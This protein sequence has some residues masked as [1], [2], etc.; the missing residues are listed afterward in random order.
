MEKLAAAGRPRGIFGS[1]DIK[2]FST[3]TRKHK[4]CIGHDKNCRNEVGV[5]HAFPR[6]LF[7]ESFPVHLS[8]YVF[9]TVDMSVNIYKP[10]GSMNF[11]M[12]RVKLQKRKSQGGKYFS[13]VVTL[14]MAI[15]ESLPEYENID[16]LEIKLIDGE[17][18]LRPVKRVN[19]I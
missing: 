18:V 9:T 5:E 17:I 10:Y 1:E 12:V 3:P 2:T 8:T 14:P 11:S 13:Y 6:Y 15:V 16:E 4:R 7:P 19:A